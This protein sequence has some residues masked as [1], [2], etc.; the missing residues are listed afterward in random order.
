MKVILKA[1]LT[2][3]GKKG[4]IVNVS[5]G[6]ARNYLFP[7]GLAIEANAL[8]LNNAAL[9]KQA[10]FH[11]KEQ[12]KEAAQQVAQILEQGEVALKAK[13]GTA[14]R[15]FGAVTA[16]EVSSAIKES[17]GIDVDKKKIVMV[18]IK[19]LGEYQL[20]IKLYAGVQAALKLIVE[21]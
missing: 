1:D 17:M 11:K 16:A 20:T 15:L 5:D 3:K 14:G 18:P 21:A 8:N 13:C 6:Y 7:R 19:E 2:E 10:A 9:A 12:E 4:E